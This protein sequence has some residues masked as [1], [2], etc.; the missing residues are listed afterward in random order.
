M[1]GTSLDSQAFE[2][3]ANPYRCR[4]LLALFDANPQTDDDVDPVGLLA[5]EDPSDN[6]VTTRLEV[7]QLHLPKLAEMGFIEWNPEVGELSEG[8][9]WT[10]VAPLLRVIHGTCGELPHS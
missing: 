1:V 2:A 5:E 3:L 4:L 9:N 6:H 8:P 10:E 7:A